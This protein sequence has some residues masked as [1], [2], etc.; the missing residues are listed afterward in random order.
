MAQLFPFSALRPTSE[1]VKA[2][3]CPPYDV[4]TTE[5][6][7][8]L[9]K[10]YPESLLHVTLPEIDGSASLE[11]L[12]QRSSHALSTLASQLDVMIK[13][14]DSF[15]YLYEQMHGL[16]T[17]M[18]IFGTVHTDDYHSG[19]IKRHELTRPDKVEE[20]TQ[21]ILAQRAHV[22]PVMLTYKNSPALKAC[23]RSAMID[24]IPLYDF[25]DEQEIRHRVYRAHTESIKDIQ[26]TF[27]DV[28]LYIADGH[29]RCEAAYQASERLVSTYSECPDEAK[30]F[31][32]VLIP[33]DELDILSYNRY[34]KHLEDLRWAD[35][36]DI[37]K[38]EPSDASLPSHAGLIKVGI[39]DH[40]YLG[41]LPELTQ[42]SEISGIDAQRLQDTILE[43]LYGIKDI[44]RD[45]R[46]GFTGG[47][48]S[49]SR[50]IEGLSSG[51]IDIA[52]VMYPV[53]I[54]DLLRVSDAGQLMP[55]K[56]TWFEPKLRSG[57]I[58]HTF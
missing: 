26:A 4:L 10:P 30:R 16:K 31:P 43:P 34:L 46:I 15:F 21:H 52:F 17:R 22:E 45:H 1:R 3:S 13:D 12:S 28:N 57:I 24:A 25:T 36:S 9:A 23:I 29:H 37:L 48:E 58:I 40:W 11:E 54:D 44:R 32:A 49:I 47:S 19:K 5:Q 20:R 39:G 27:K 8:E 50:M 35:L 42:K 56:S 33:H 51:N 18:G 41:S 38:L 2:V 7:K 53:D 55:P 14:D 6:A